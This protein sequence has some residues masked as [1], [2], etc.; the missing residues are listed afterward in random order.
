[1]SKR[2]LSVFSSLKS[3]SIFFFLCS[4]FS[5]RAVKELISKKKGYRVSHQTLKFGKKVLQDQKSLSDPEYQVAQGANIDC[6][7]VARR[8]LLSDLCSGLKHK[9]DLKGSDTVRNRA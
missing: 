5:K 7:L 9:I 8:V 2:L 4:F 1:M 6:F 3:D